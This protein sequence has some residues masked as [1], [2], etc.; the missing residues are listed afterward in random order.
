VVYE[1]EDTRLGRRVALKL[2][3]DELANDPQAR[4]R[5]Q[6]EARAASA[7]NHPNI[8]TIELALTEALYGNSSQARDLIPTALA[9]TRSRYGF[10]NAGFALAVLADWRAAQISA[11]LEKQYPIKHARPRPRYPYHSGVCGSDPRQL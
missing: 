7:L 6:R 5:F 9:L 11:D 10:R 1:A 3:P 2:L 8:C 4:D